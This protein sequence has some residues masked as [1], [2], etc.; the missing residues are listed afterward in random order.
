MGLTTRTGILA[1]ADEVEAQ[2]ALALQQAEVK[3][4][5]GAPE[6]GGSE[7]GAQHSI[8]HQDEYQLGGHRPEHPCSESPDHC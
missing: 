3:R 2:V 1:H 6:D 7:P 4:H 5:H 8:G